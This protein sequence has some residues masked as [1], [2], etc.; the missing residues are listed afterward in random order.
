MEKII[1]KVPEYKTVKNGTRDIVY[2]VTFDGQEFTSEKQAKK[3]ENDLLVA[4]KFEGISRIF[5]RTTQKIFP[6]SDWYFPRTAEE[7]ELLKDRLG[8]NSK[9]NVY[10]NDD[11]RINL[12]INQWIMGEREDG[13]DYTDIINFYTLDYVKKDIDK[14]L[15]YFEETK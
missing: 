9:C 11:Y 10:V 12:V 1:K 8:Y 2:F 13:G 5:I 7:L 6:D 4:K 3:Y 14:F 15:R